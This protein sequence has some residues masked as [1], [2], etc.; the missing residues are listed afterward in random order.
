MKMHSI[1]SHHNLPNPL[2]TGLLLQKLHIG[3]FTTGRKSSRLNPRIFSGGPG[4][5]L[6]NLEIC[7]CRHY[8]VL[9]MLLSSLLWIMDD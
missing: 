6:L 8:Y 9:W 5:I 3:N 7:V 4:E 2:S 1:L